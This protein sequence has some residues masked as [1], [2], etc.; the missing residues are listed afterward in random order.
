M[1]R[2][3]GAFQN[4]WKGSR[5]SRRKHSSQVCR[6]TVNGPLPGGAMNPDIRHNGKPG[7]QLAV[8][9][10]EI[11]KC[12]AFQ[13][14]PIDILDRPLDLSLG[15]WPVRRTCNRLETPMISK[16]TERRLN[17]SRGVLCAGLSDDL[18]EIVEEQLVGNST[19]LAETLFQKLDKDGS[20]FGHDKPCPDESG[21]TENDDQQA[22]SPPT[23][24]VH[25]GAARFPVDLGLSAGLGF[26]SVDEA[27]DLFVFDLGYEVSEDGNSAVVVL[28]LYLS[29]QDGGRQVESLETALDI[30]F[31]WIEFTRASDRTSRIIGLIDPV[32]DGLSADAELTGDLGFGYVFS[33]QL[34]HFGPHTRYHG[35][36]DLLF[37]K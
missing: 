19:D 35:C 22:Q 5:V 36:G 6:K 33:K 18:F 12:P 4:A 15:L 16:L 26:K 14:V 2:Q 29:K 37:E 20:S 34:L 28:L 1:V 23:T 30:G 11:G 32:V 25:D 9:I 7:A 31:E 17:L 13:K 21:I 27:R 10:I 3:A 24:V 8:E